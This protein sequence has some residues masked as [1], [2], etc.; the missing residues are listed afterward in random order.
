MIQ[1]TRHLQWLKAVLCSVCLQIQRVLRSVF[2]LLAG[3]HGT[4]E[5]GNIFLGFPAEQEEIS[6]LI[7]FFLTGKDTHFNI[8]YC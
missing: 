7:F 2:G 6:N 3:Q 1:S 4:L 5:E 8:K